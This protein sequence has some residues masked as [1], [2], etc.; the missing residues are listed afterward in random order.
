MLGSAL[1]KWLVHQNCPVVK[2]VRRP[3]RDKVCEVYWDPLKKEIDSSKLIDVDVVIHLAGVNV[4]SGIWT[5]KKKKAIMDSRVNSTEFLSEI[6][7]KMPSKPKLLIIASGI[8]IYGYNNSEDEPFSEESPENGKD[9]LSQ[10]VRKWEAATKPVKDAGVRTCHL[11]F[12]AI[13]SPL[14]GLIKK[15]LPI[16][17]FGIGG[18]LGSGKQMMSWVDLDDTV[19]AIWHC[20]E[21]ETLEGPINVVA[22]EAISNKQFTKAYSKAV[23]MPN[24]IPAPKFILANFL[25]EMAECLMLS[26][27]KCVPKK[28]LESGFE[29][30]YPTIRESLNH[31]LDSSVPEEAQKAMPEEGEEAAEDEKK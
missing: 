24:F 13:L 10:V 31:Q 30:K 15:T 23:G 9:Y 25:G 7:G 19:G 4:A 14:G 8:N 12:G 5:S 21:N 3:V 2:L 1:T 17:K 22:P 11:R 27:I 16:F 26:S 18:K 20:M 29:F 6:I 28:L